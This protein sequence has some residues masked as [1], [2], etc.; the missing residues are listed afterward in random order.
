MEKLVGKGLIC[1]GFCGEVDRALGSRCLKH[2]VI[3]RGCAG[4]H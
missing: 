2:T 1:G 3:G 4:C